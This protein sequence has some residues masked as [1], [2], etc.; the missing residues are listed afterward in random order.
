MISYCVDDDRC[1][2]TPRDGFPICWIFRATDHAVVVCLLFMRVSLDLFCYS[3][4]QIDSQYRYVYAI[5]LGIKALSNPGGWGFRTLK[6]PPM[7]DRIM[8]AAMETTMLRSAVNLRAD[9]I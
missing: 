4:S 5:D 1:E 8:M 6:S 7:M 9:V 2:Y 3:A